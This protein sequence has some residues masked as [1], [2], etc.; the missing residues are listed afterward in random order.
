MRGL[1]CGVAV[2]GVAAAAAAAQTPIERGRYLVNGVLACGNCHT[3]KGPNGPIVEKDLSGGLKFDEPPFTVTASNITPDPD[4]GIGKWSAAEIKRAL[5]DG[6]RPNGVPLAP[7]MPYAFY[8]VLTPRDLDAVVA[9]LR[10]VPAI[11]NEVPAPV[12]RAVIKAQPLPGAERPI[13]ESALADKVKRGFYLATIGHCMECHTPQVNGAPDVP[14]GIGKGGR[15]F[16][17]PWG[18]SVSPNITSHPTAGLGAWSDDEI[19]RAIAQGIG[20]DGRRLKPPMAYDYYAK[21][22]PDD[23]AAMVAW[24][25]TVPARQ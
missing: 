22:S 17:G 21:I 1:L 6:E 2:L 25:R 16:P 10:S 15:E 18:V 24:L 20:R 23:L 11:R 9:Y 4:T 19:K 5:I 3:P 12:Y 8:K 7:I 14:N 13:P